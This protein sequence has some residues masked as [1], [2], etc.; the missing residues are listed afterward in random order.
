VLRSFSVCSSA[1]V[2][3]LAAPHPS[4]AIMAGY[5]DFEIVESA[6]VETTL[7]HP[8]IRNALE[9]WLEMIHGAR[10]SLDF[11]EFYASE[12]PNDPN[13]PI[14]Q[15]VTAIE[16]AAKRGVK[17]RFV[18]SSS[19]YKTYPQVIDRL[20]A[21]IGDGAVLLLDFKKV[22][23]GVLHAKY[24]IVDGET[25]Y[26][27]SQNFDWR[28][29]SQ[30]QEL[31]VRVRDRTVAATM[32]AVYEYDWRTALAQAK[33]QVAGPM[34]SI[35]EKFPIVKEMAPGE[36]A[37][38]TP[39]ASPQHFL[40]PGVPWDEPLLVAMIDSAKTSVEVQLL[41]YKPVSDRAYY[42]VL[43]GA[44]RRAA[45][46]GVEVRLLCADWCKRASTIP[47]L[48]SL[49]V[50]P[51][52]EVKL[53]TI[54]E[55]SRGFIPY[56]RVIHSKYM[57]VDGRAAWIG[58]SNWERDYFHES[59][60]VGITVENEKI[61]GILHRFFTSGWESAYAYRVDPAADYKPPRIGE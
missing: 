3:L 30:I 23:G 15:V 31:G 58:T 38:I 13:D 39:V 35:H 8:A 36:T 57:V 49:T 44:L 51:N 20:R 50:V 27:G 29:L 1:V 43:D 24:F 21:S 59:R 12:D 60:N 55:S 41:T 10:T 54:P 42:D 61:A 6:P 7:D 2:V 40:P 56:A 26:L 14:D 11:A 33:V 22:A 4:T 46:R 34:P 32:A 18:S 48:K 28:A 37:R 9:V 47:H 17:V 52:I 5:P 25:V 53:M 45:A 19:F 16:A